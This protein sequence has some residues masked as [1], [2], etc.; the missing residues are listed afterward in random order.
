MDLRPFLLEQWLANFEQDIK[1]NLGASTGPP[2]TVDELVGLADADA[3]R[4]MFALA[5]TY[6]P[7]DG[8]ASLR[9]AIADLQGV[10]PDCVQVVTGAAEA[11]LILYWLAAEPGANVIV[12]APGYPA[13]SALPQSLGLETRYYRFEK[14]R[15]FAVEVEEIEALADRKT[16]L[17]LVSNPHSPTGAI[18]TDDQ[19]DHLHAF[20]SDR[21]IQLV[22]DEVYHPIHHSEKVQSA[23]R[24]PRATVIN[25]FSKALSLPGLRVGWIIEHD[26][27]KRERYWNAR[28]FSTVCSSSLGEFLAEIAVNKREKIIGRAQEITSRNLRVLTEFMHENES[29]FGWIPPRGGMVAFPWMHDGQNA[30]AF[31]LAAAGEGLL[32]TPGD[33]YD[34][35]EHFR[36]GMGASGDAFLGAIK[37]LHRFVNH[38][39]S[40]RENRSHHAVV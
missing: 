12:P 37:H 2:W 18:L 36:I 13:F 24:L 33:V 15:G 31:C 3:R 20:T 7:P 8:N 30:R 26:A 39:R 34:Q 27:Q 22:S 28:A 25:D 29:V 21:G 32:L 23:A 1:Y 40:G 10:S 9:A 17:I 38:W 14:E 4:R 35:P 11:L 16:K 6:G 5:L 19:M